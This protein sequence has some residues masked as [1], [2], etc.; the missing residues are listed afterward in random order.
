MILSPPLSIN[1]SLFDVH[2]IVRED[3]GIIFHPDTLAF[4]KVDVKTA[5]IVRDIV[6]GISPTQAAIKYDLPI[7]KIEGFLATLQNEINHQANV[8]PPKLYDTEL[9]GDRLILLVSQDCNLRCRY[10]NASGGDYGQGR[11]LMSPA[12]AVHVIENF[13]QDGE[14]LFQGVQFFGG[15]PTMNLAAV[16]AVCEYLSSAYRDGRITHMPW[17]A[18]IT[19]GIQVSDKFV[20]LIQDYQIKVT[21]SIDGPQNLHDHY[22]VDLGGRGTYHRVT[23]N[24]KKLRA[25]TGDQKPEAVEA[26][27]TCRHLKEGYNHRSLQQFFEEEL[28][29]HRTHLALIEAGYDKAGR[30]TDQERTQWLIDAQASV[31]QDLMRGEPWASTLGLRLLK[32]LVFKRIS[33]YLC[34]VGIAALT[35]NV[36]GSIYPCYQLMDPSFYMGKAIEKGVWK[37]A[38]YQQ[39]EQRMRASDKFHNAKCKACWARGVCSGCLGELFAATGSINHRMEPVCNG[40]RGGLEEVLYGL[41]KLRSDPDTWR[42]ILENLKDKST[43]PGSTSEQY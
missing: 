27:V 25:V 7:T 36:D 14:F 24:L 23:K 39:V 10:C 5:R 32:K 43:Q 8:R 22:R 11:G 21:F 29:I 12:L 20:R 3:V 1:T 33:P 37:T 17:F 19:N 4:F 13:V 16:R 31:I 34:P 38:T 42:Q 6:E 18:L 2:V 9:L 40:T 35:V 41:L 15:E 30:V 28:G 26:T